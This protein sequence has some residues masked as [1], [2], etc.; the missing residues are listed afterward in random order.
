M[1]PGRSAP[2]GPC[3]QGSQGMDG[4]GAVWQH[5]DGDAK[6]R[7]PGMLLPG[8]GRWWLQLQL[9]RA[10]SKGDQPR[11]ARPLQRQSGPPPPRG[12]SHCCQR[13]DG[14]FVWVA[15]GKHGRRQ[16]RH[17]CDTGCCSPAV[18]ALG[19]S[20]S[21]RIR[22]RQQQQARR[23]FLRHYL[24]TQRPQARRRIPGVGIRWW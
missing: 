16:T 12:E 11:W 5:E 10:K 22:A 8:R 18:L 7:R 9:P 14:V 15:A 21:S 1:A 3:R 19:R 17:P 13:R 23:E 20:C 24:W 6:Q 4:G 2:H